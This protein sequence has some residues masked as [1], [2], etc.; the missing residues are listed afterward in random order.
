MVKTKH[1]RRAAGSADK[2]CKR[3][4]RSPDS[5]DGWECSVCT[6]RNKAESFRCEMCDVRKGTS[7]RKPRLN[8]TVVEQQQTVQKFAQ[9]Q[10]QAL[11]SHAHKERSRERNSLC[12]SSL[13]DADS[14]G[15]SN[16]SLESP[17]SCSG[18]SRAAANEQDHQSAEEESSSESDDGSAPSDKDVEKS[19]IKPHRSSTPTLQPP[20]APS[21]SSSATNEDPPAPKVNTPEKGVVPVLSDSSPPLLTAEKVSPHELVSDSVVATLEIIATSSTTAE[22]SK[23]EEMNTV[24]NETPEACTDAPPRPTR[25]RKKGSLNSISRKPPRTFFRRYV[26]E[27][28]ARSMEITVRGVTVLFTDYK[29]IGDPQKDDTPKS[30]TAVPAEQFDNFNSS[31]DATN[32][33]KTNDNWT[34]DI[35][36]NGEHLNCNIVDT[37]A[38]IATVTSSAEQSS[39]QRKPESIDSKCNPEKANS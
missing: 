21:E 36:N 39:K 1:H 8:S 37:N 31:K 9:Q 24:P 33:G 29:L 30:T 17:F 26:D 35:L 5:V 20:A 10:Q 12:G 27:Q 38:N 34:K 16:R 14:P 7:T 18:S 22:T 15:P 19:S 32:T 6:F 28:S 11:I 23:S 25:G 3:R 13:Y 2:S 4:R